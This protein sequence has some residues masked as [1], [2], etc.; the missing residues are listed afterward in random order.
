MPTLLV[1]DDEPAI[2][3]A[4]QKAFQGKDIALRSAGTSAEAVKIFAAIRPDVVVLDVHLPDASGLETFKRFRTIDARI[5][6]PPC[7]G[8]IRRAATVQ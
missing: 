3:H 6:S 8:R 2:Q 7:T 5:S 1:V 4:F